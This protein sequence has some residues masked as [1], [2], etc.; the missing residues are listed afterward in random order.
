MLAVLF[1]V[2]P[3][4]LAAA[5]QPDAVWTFIMVVG[6]LALLVLVLRNWLRHRIGGYTGDTLGAAEQLGEL[7]VLLIFV[8]QW[9]Q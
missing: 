7:T 9:S 1:G 6:A 2:V 5:V 4:A 8:A 3:L